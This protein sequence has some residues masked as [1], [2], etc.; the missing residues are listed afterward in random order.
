MSEALG[1]ALITPE[2]MDLL[3]K[4]TRYEEL[5]SLRSFKDAVR[6][7]KE[8]KSAAYREQM[9]YSYTMSNKETA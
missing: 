8:L 5:N 3:L 2:N 9:F 4:H 6:A 1:H 7:I